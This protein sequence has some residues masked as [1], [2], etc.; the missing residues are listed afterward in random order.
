M[1]LIILF[2]LLS[3]GANAQII[4][5][6]PFYVGMVV[7]SGNLLLDDYPN[8]IIGY[9]LRKLDKDYTGSAI[10]IRRD[11]TGNA[12][13]DI[14]FLASGELDT[15]AI[16]NHCRNNSCFVTTW[17]NQADSSGTFGIKNATQSTALNQPRIVNAGTIDRQSGK[18]AIVFDG[19]NDFFTFDAFTA[20]T[21]FNIF[22]VVKRN[23]TTTKA[24]YFSTSG[25]GSLFV[26]WSDG[27]FY[28]QYKSVSTWYYKSVSSSSIT[29]NLYEG[30]TGGGQNQKVYL[31][32]SQL[33]LS[34]RTNFGSNNANWGNIGRYSANN[35]NV[36]AGQALEMIMYQ[37]DQQSN[38]SGISTNIN[39]F[40]SLW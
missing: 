27:N 9:S 5:A 28:I 8:A 18:V 3:V 22:T 40:Y 38:R 12:E 33:T 13:T 14:G 25:T 31:N 30:F 21:I 16:K 35:A 4:R 34:S 11:S 39:S 10:R 24:P 19:S 32:N 37:S 1:R 6:N 2:L 20:D 17:Y 36:P 26:H 23:S 15:T 7:S 29:L